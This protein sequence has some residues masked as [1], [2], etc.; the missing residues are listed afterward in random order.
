MTGRTTAHG[1]FGFGG[2]ADV[3]LTRW[4]SLRMEVRDFVTGKGL[5][6][7]GGRHH[8]LPAIGVAFHH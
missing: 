2:G 1:V 8:V 6:G 5:G 7:A 3:R 4:F